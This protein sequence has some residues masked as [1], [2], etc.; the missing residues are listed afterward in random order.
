MQS[1][2]CLFSSSASIITPEDLKSTPSFSSSNI[3]SRPATATATNN[4][5]SATTTGRIVIR[6]TQPQ[7]LS[8]IANLLSYEAIQQQQRNRNNAPSSTLLLHKTS[9]S[10]MS[11]PKFSWNWNDQ[12]S[13]LKSHSNLHLQLTHRLTA[14]R[15]L[16]PSSSSVVV[17]SS[18]HSNRF[19]NA[20][21]DNTTCNTKLSALLNHIW[22]HNDTLRH[23]VER[24]VRTT[25]DFYKD[26]ISWWQDWNFALTPKR[27]MMFHFMMTAAVDDMECFVGKEDVEPVGFCELMMLKRPLLLQDD[28]GVMRNGEEE[29]EQEEVYVPCIVNLVVS[30]NH[31]RRGIGKRLVDCA[32]RAVRVYGQE[33]NVDLGVVG[34]F[35]EKGNLGAI[36]LYEKVGFRVVE[37]DKGDCQGQAS[38]QEQIYMEMSMVDDDRMNEDYVSSSSVKSWNMGIRQREQEGVII[39]NS[40]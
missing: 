26:D 14:K 24:A 22:I 34:L 38:G 25:L 36:A 20:L 37:N 3:I 19:E 11:L 12:I 31:R 29:E 1:L 6:S 7:D 39:G 17:V 2:V 5:A 30:P 35:V 18:S 4:A 32:V 13:K 33:W 16:Y 27:E 8:A 10:S 9:S 28:R 40:R 21:D 15:A 23:K